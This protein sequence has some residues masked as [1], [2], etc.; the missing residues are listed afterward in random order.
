MKLNCKIYPFFGVAYVSAPPI[1]RRRFGAGHFV[2]GHFG[3]GTIGCQ[4]FFFRF[5]FLQLSCFGLQLAS[6]AVG[7]RT[8]VSTGSRS[9]ALKKL[10]A[11]LFFLH[12]PKNKKKQETAPKCPVP[13]R[14]GA[15]LSSAE[16]AA[17]K[18][19]RRNGPP[20]IFC[21]VSANL[22]STKKNANFFYQAGDRRGGGVHM[23]GYQVC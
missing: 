13:K 22:N 12:N 9:T 16:S 5:V 15:Q 14:H 23:L 8:L 6:L 7:L 20:P 17:P 18:R 4:N 3:A 21:T 2:A 1:R 11:S 19:R 10:P